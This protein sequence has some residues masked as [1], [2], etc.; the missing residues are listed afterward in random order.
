MRRSA[1]SFDISVPQE[2]STLACTA[3]SRTYNID[4][5]E[6]VS[7]E[8]TPAIANLPLLVIETR[9]ILWEREMRCLINGT[10]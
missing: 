10:L 8:Y 2:K 1:Q 4:M 5:G 6:P 9:L 7:Q 3:T